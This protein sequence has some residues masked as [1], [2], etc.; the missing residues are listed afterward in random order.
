MFVKVVQPIGR[1]SKPQIRTWYDND[2][3]RKIVMQAVFLELEV[4]FN[5]LKY[6]ETF[7]LEELVEVEGTLWVIDLLLKHLT[8]VFYIDVWVLNNLICR[9]ANEYYAVASFMKEE[10]NYF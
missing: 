4:S 2:F 6:E 8:E 10:V 9:F 1:I 7:L 3:P 5:V